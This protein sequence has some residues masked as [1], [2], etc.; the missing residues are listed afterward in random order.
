MVELIKKIHE[1]RRD[2]TDFATVYFGYISEYDYER[3]TA[4]LSSFNHRGISWYTLLNAQIRGATRRTSKLI[5]AI[6]G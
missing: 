5:Q 4:S 6:G 1:I 3:Y 2:S